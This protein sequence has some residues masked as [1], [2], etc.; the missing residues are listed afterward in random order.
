M[1]WKLTRKLNFSGIFGDFRIYFGY[2]WI[3]WFGWPCSL[4]WRCYFMF[5][6][7]HRMFYFR[8]LG[9]FTLGNIYLG[10]AYLLLLFTTAWPACYVPAYLHCAWLT[11]SVNLYRSAPYRTLLVCTAP[12]STW[13]FI[14]ANKHVVHLIL[15][16]CSKYISSIF[17]VKCVSYP[18]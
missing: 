15:P 13:N 8:Y 2:F 18:K 7:Y 10:F 17:Y 11:C 14:Y 16:I 4:F 9:I 3:L 1:N 5:V 6:K 12:Y